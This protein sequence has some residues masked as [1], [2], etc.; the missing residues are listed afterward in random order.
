MRC[1]DFFVKAV[2]EFYDVIRALERVH[3]STLA[4]DRNE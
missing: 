4:R 2:T 1:L 3:W